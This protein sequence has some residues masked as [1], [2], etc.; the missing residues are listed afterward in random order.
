MNDLHNAI[1]IRVETS[2]LPEQSL[3]ESERFVFAYTIT[4]TNRGRDAAKLMS[5]YWL[6]T[7][8]NG[9]TQEVRVTVS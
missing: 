7:D 3:P 2:Y 8:G 6:I 9:R 5:R 4:L 1:D